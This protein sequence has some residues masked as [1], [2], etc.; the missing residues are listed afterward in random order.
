MLT[1]RHAVEGCTQV[2]VSKDKHRL[3]GQV[4]AVSPRYDLAL[5]KIPKTLGLAAVFP[6]EVAAHPNDMVFAGAYDTLAAA[7][8]GSGMLSN[9]RVTS[10][11]GSGEEGLLA[12]DSPV[13]FWGK[14]RACVG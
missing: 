7:K 9:A 10:S 1:A 2:V 4:A 12:I 11:F 8:L 13:T 6:N 3:S 14:R 5:L